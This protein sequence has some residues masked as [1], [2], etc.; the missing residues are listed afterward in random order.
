[1]QC[2]AIVPDTTSTTY[3]RQQPRYAMKDKKTKDKEY[4]A[5]QRKVKHVTYITTRLPRYVFSTTCWVSVSINTMRST[6]RH[7]E[8]WLA[9]RQLAWVA[10]TEGVNLNFAVC[11]AKAGGG[12]EL[13]TDES[14]FFFF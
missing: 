4:T 1:M 14:V 3:T 6:M 9:V 12:I 7:H 8:G 5:C 10:S 11:E 2:H 13:H